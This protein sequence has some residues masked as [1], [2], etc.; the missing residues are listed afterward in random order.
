MT[1][2]AAI[3]DAPIFSPTSSLW[4]CVPR[5]RAL[6]SSSRG[7]ENPRLIFNG[8]FE[9]VSACSPDAA[10]C[11][12]GFF[13]FE[14]PSSSFQNGAFFASTT[15]GSAATTAAATA[16]AFFLREPPSSS[17][18]NGVF[19]ASTASGSEATTAAAVTAA[20]SAFFLR[21]PPSSFFQNG[22]EAPSAFGSLACL[23]RLLR[24]LARRADLLLPERD[25]RLGGHRRQLGLRHGWMDDLRLGLGVD[26]DGRRDDRRGQRGREVR[27]ERILDVGRGQGNLDGGRQDGGREHL[28]GRRQHRLGGQRRRLRGRRLVLGRARMEHGVDPRDGVQ[29]LGLDEG[30][31][32]LGLGEQFRGRRQDGLGLRG[33]LCGEGL[34]LDGDDFRLRDELRLRGRRR[35]GRGRKRGL[36]RGRGRQLDGSSYGRLLILRGER[37]E[38]RLEEALHLCRIR[39]FAGGRR[40]PQRQRLVEGRRLVGAGLGLAS[41]RQL[42]LPDRGL[43]G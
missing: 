9:P 4:C 11:F 22:V 29:R 30:R 18:Q 36:G 20:A 35:L 25:L 13:F 26:G 38:G 37:G 43:L 15:E 42:L 6:P 12:F 39:A 28:G 2:A 3:C 40:G 14:P 17:F 21:E 23:L 24:L 16:P 32:R 31:H 10:S 1:R 27:Y 19:F 34:R 5:P 41:E 8:F 33:R 7:I